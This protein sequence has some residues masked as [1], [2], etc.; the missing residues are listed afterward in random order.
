ME[1]TGRLWSFSLAIYDRPGV[2]EACLALQDSRGADVNRLLHA[3]WCGALGHRITHDERQRLDEQ[4]APWHAH[5]VRPLRGVRQWLKGREATA[6]GEAAELRQQIKAQELEA[7][8]LEQL[9]LESAL[10]PPAA[11]GGPSHAAANLLALIPAPDGD[12]RDHLLTLLKATWPQ[13]DPTRLSGLF[14]RE[15]E[16]D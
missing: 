11:T 14:P 12:E 2:P 6:L 3:L 7:E 16:Q 9:L 8:R 5:V 4:A 13:L 1:H 15:H 10:A